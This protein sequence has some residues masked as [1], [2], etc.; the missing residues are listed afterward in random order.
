LKLFTCED[1]GL[2]FWCC[3]AC[4]IINSTDQ[5]FHCKSCLKKTKMMIICKNCGNMDAIDKEDYCVDCLEE[6]NDRD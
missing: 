1:C 3:I 5:K 6:L 2:Q 4:V